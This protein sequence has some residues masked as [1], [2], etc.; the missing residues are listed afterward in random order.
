MTVVSRA[1]GC[2]AS[3]A[4]PLLSGRRHRSRRQSYHHSEREFSKEPYWRQNRNF[5][6]E[7]GGEWWHHID[8][9][10]TD[11]FVILVSDVVVPARLGTRFDIG[12]DAKRRSGIRRMTI[13]GL[14]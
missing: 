6:S 14:Q 5:H 12:R 4:E 8:T 11:P 9:I 13:G 7:P 3:E 2:I 10:R 1:I